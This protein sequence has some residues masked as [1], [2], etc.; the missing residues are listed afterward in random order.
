MA[1]TMLVTLLEPEDAT[2]VRGTGVEVL[3]EYP[4]SML[5]RGTD[6]Q[7]TALTGRGVEV[8]T[9]PDQATQVAGATFAFADAVRAQDAAPVDQRPGRTAYYLVKL[10]GPAAP[11]WLNAVRSLGVTVLDSLPG[12]TLLVGMLPERVEALAAL[13]WVEDVTPYRAAMKVS[14]KL[15]RG[16]P[17]DLGTSLLTGLSA[18]DLSGAESERVEVTVFPGESVEEVAARIRAANG[19]V[20]TTAGRTV[21]GEVGPAVIA[22]LAATQSVQAVLPFAFAELHNDRALAVM[23]VPTGHTFAGR[24][25]TGRGQIVGIADSGLDTGNPDRMHPDI[26]GRVHGITSLPTRAGLAQLI[27]DPPG[28]DDGPADGDSGHGTHVTGSVLGDGA[29]AK[30]IGSAFVPAGAAP[31]ARVYFQAIG[32]RVHWKSAEQLAAEGVPVNPAKWPPATAGLWGLPDDI[33]EV[34]AQAY[35]RDA[36]IHTNSWGAP[37]AGV[38]DAT[39]RAVD[40]FMWNNP[41]MLI[42]FSAGNDGK[43]VENPSGVVDPDSIGTPGTAKN[44]LTVGASENDRPHGSMPPPGRDFNWSQTEKFPRLTGAGHVS[45]N[46]DG[47]AAFSSRGPTDDGRIKPDVVA[48]GTNVLSMLS[49]VFPPDKDPLWGRLPQNHD[50][51]DFYCWSGGTSMATPLVAG[52]AALVRERLAEIHPAPSAALIKAVLINGAVPMRGQFPGEITAGPNNVSGFG[53]VDVTAALTPEPGHEL[54]YDDDPGHSVAC[55]Q[56]RRYAVEAVGPDVPLKVTLVWTDAPSLEGVGHLVNQLY[57]QVQAPDGT[58]FD[59]DTTPFGAATN[60]V[61]QVSIVSPA[62]GAYTVRVRGLSVTEH[63]PGAT[64]ADK[65]RQTFAVVMSGGTG[66]TLK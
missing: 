44:C 6:D 55:G 21:V 15:R 20:L 62:A 61:Q 35:A 30:A 38:Y 32:Q 60:N 17:R 16:V 11:E 33:G 53:R 28:S 46:V 4:D 7:R 65:P 64:P 49:S 29:A 27:T 31:E 39:S 54:R 48:P 34:F 18:D 9:L 8:T 12:F 2:A 1:T 10:A 47:M 22:E 24:T 63:A 52:A 56:M 13:P 23:R 58:L 36:R 5:V 40:K 51:R 59:G 25:V 3:A 42:L 50:L 37:T 43:D 14:P 26:R 66:L 57:L 19:V 41:D 45:D